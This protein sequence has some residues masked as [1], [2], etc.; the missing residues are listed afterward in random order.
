MVSSWLARLVL[1]LAVLGVLALDGLAW[2]GA[3][4]GAQDSAERAGRAAVST[5]DRT[6]SLQSAYDAALTE[7][8]AS[9]DTIDT[10]GFTAAPDGAVSLTL[11][12]RVPTLVLHRVPALRHLTSVTTTVGTGPAS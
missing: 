9:G 8:G 5:W 6:A 3:R 12:R 11:R 4:L 2:A 1:A 7:V 10:A